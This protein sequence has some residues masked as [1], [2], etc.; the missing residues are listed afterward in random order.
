MNLPFSSSIRS[1]LAFAAIAAATS[2]C[3]I[4]YSPDAFDLLTNSCESDD[5]C[6]SSAACVDQ[7]CLGTNVDLS[8][9][10]VE[11]RPN[12]GASYG[13]S[14]SFILPVNKSFAALKDAAFDVH[15]D[16]ELPAALAITAGMVHVDY[17]F[18]STCT[19]LGTQKSVP[20]TITFDRL[21][22]LAG[23]R[24]DSYTVTAAKKTEESEDYEF[25]ARLLPGKYSVYIQPQ[26]IPGCPD[27][28][29]PP[30]VF[31]A[32]QEIRESVDGKGNVTDWAV[33]TPTTLEGEIQIPD[34]GDL[35]GWRLDIL[36]PSGGRVISTTQRLQQGMFAFK[37]NVKLSFV[38]NDKSVSP[39]IRL[40][41]PEGEARPSVYWGL[42]ESLSSQS[43]TSVH[44]S[45]ANLQIDPREVEIR[46]E[47]SEGNGVLSSV[48]IQSVELSGDVA[49]NA[50]YTIDIPKTDPQGL[51]KLKLPPG[52]Y[53]FRAT[54]AVDVSLA[55]GDLT[56]IVPPLDPNV[57]GN[58]CFCGR[59]LQ[60]ANKSPV[61]GTVFTPKGVNLPGASI[62]MSPSEPDAVNY[63]KRVVHAIDPRPLAPRA[64][65][66]D[67]DD[68]GGF[69]FHIDPGPSDLTVRPTDQSGFP[70]LVRPRVQVVEASG[71][72]FTELT[73][74]NA[75][76]LRG[77]VTD[78]SGAPARNVTVDGWRP[79]RN[80]GGAAPTTV[81]QIG[82]TTT[83]ENGHYTLVLPSSISQ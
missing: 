4:Q 59:V 46:V 9:L 82:S 24:F 20:A 32:S 83:D 54:P 58:P 21:T 40:R 6:A 48:Q 8:D 64:D 14:T 35:T 66:A 79:V 74:P 30:P 33:I 78:P 50:A 76:I 3:S 11:V 43:T 25:D 47:D 38:W 71:V 61:T 51:F 57:P 39:Y 17:E 49:K 67:T 18:S 62:T 56:L 19:N 2:G 55:S 75:A 10:I 68:G 31:Y 53:Q 45:V 73:L 65:I 7:R 23:F 13:A 12:S 5:D 60:V 77:T 42:I 81:I 16:I 26:P 29:P 69:A 72:Q 52:T 70:W 28:A 37:V 41:P 27:D 36:E 22:D 63:W 44:L 34:G 80:E 1:T 15:H